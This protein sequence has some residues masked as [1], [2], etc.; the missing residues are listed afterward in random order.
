MTC[1]V[2]L[3]YH[4]SKDYIPI[5]K[6]N[7]RQLNFSL[8]SLPTIPSKPVVLNQGGI[9]LYPGARCSVSKRGS[10]GKMIKGR[11]TS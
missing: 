4:K 8:L 6:I 5:S 7:Y 10:D 11:G 3:A 9:L 1:C 2:R